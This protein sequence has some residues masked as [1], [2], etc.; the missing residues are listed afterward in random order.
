M[1]RSEEKGPEDAA[2]KENIALVTAVFEIFTL[3]KQWFS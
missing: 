3:L 2:K 1:G